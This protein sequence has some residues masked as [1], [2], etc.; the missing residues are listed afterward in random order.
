MS[1]M[2]RPVPVLA[3][4]GCGLAMAAAA[5]PGASGTASK[6]AAATVLLA[7]C[8]VLAAFRWRAAATCAVLLVAVAIGLADP[9][10]VAAAVAG[11]AAVGHLLLRHAA[12]G[13][14]TVTAPALIGAATFSVVG[15]IAAGFPLQL[16]WLPLA[17]APAVLAGYLLALRPFLATPTRRR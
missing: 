15:V 3:S 10:T 6:P 14:A 7:V 1:T 9:P 4:V 5:V 17:A 12:G 8:A 11:L 2:A 16:P 13:T